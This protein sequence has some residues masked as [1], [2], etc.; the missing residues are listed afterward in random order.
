M[1]TA[2]APPAF[3]GSR[4]GWGDLPRDLRARIQQLAGA[5]VVSEST[6][7]N[8]FSPG[9]AST[10]ELGDGTSVFVKAV[11]PDLNP[12][13]PTLARA[14]IHVNRLLPAEARAPE[15]VFAA[16][17]GTWVVLGFA[18]VD[19]ATPGVP[20]DPDELALALETVARL[21]HVPA[22]DGL[23]DLRDLTQDL[24]T[25]WRR[26]AADTGDLRAALTAVPEHADWLADALARLGTWEEAGVAASGGD[27]LV[28][29]DLRGDN[30]LVEHLPGG[31]RR[32]W[33]VDWPHAS[34][35]APVFDV[36]GM[37]PSVAMAGGGAA[38]DVFARHPGAHGLDLADVRDVLAGIAGYFVRSAVQPAPP[39]IPNLRAFQLAQ[40]RAAL[41]WLRVLDS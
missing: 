12:D 23:R 20:W 2:P 34:A 27:R 5:E 9:F 35:G 11:A 24:F 41:E 14:E 22:P 19:G 21:A 28:H 4:L 37:L 8:G 7:T 25:G 33:L 26:L 3:S 18:V 38:V 10:L 30:M 13:S 16:D 29:A 1:S 15:L 40:G 32:I 6:A 36:V 39:G 31:A 17:D